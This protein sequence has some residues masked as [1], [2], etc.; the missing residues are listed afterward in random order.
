MWGQTINLKNRLRNTNTK[1]NKLLQHDLA[2]IW[3]D[4]F[5]LVII[6]DNIPQSN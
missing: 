4:D 1:P 2:T 5:E 3:L 6:E